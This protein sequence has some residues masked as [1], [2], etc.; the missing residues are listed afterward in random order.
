M[1][2]SLVKI[3]KKKAD[4]ELTIATDHVKGQSV[5]KEANRLEGTHLGLVVWIPRELLNK[6]I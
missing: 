5:A 2:G 3:H 6:S 1:H 4:I